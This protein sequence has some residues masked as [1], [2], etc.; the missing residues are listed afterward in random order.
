MSD[1]SVEMASLGNYVTDTTFDSPTRTLTRS[2]STVFRTNDED[3]SPVLRRRI[4]RSSLHIPDKRRP[5]SVADGLASVGRDSLRFGLPAAS[6]F[7]R[8]TSTSRL[9]KVI[10][11][12]EIDT[13]KSALVR[14]YVHNFYSDNYNATV[15]VDF[16]LKIIPFNDDLEV[17]LQLWD[18]AGQERFSSMTRAYYRG[19]MGAIV[20]YDQTNAYTYRSA[21]DRW[22]RDLDAKCCLPGNRPVPAILVGNKCDL[23][24]DKNMPDDLEISRD[25][26]EHGFVPKWYKTS[27]KTGKNVNDAMSLIV[28]Y[29]MAMDDWSSPADQNQSLYVP[30]EVVLL[31]NHDQKPATT[32]TTTKKNLVKPCRIC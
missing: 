14:R 11:I 4:H 21:V 9:Y 13:G 32:G 30:P 17:R 20:V 5:I 26:Q 22:K 12:G 19:T 1:E 25:V 28:K 3:S 29:I 2:S 10:V 27:A 24:P 15:G 18:I 7:Y 23:I 6:N 31:N 8:S 16:R